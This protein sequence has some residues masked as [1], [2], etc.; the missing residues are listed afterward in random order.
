[1]RGIKIALEEEQDYYVPTIPT[2]QIR[3]ASI[4]LYWV[5]LALGTL[6]YTLACFN[7]AN[8]VTSLE[9]NKFIKI[10]RWPLVVFFYLM[11]PLFLAISAASAYYNLPHFQI[12]C[13]LLIVA[14]LFE[15]IAFFYCGVKVLRMLGKISDQ[16]HKSKTALERKV[17]DISI[18]SSPHSI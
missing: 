1:M 5:P 8:I 12:F 9:D 17:C 10:M 7:W 4:S 13:A 3:V 2:F 14:G 11:I 16:L 6:S 18:A 15:T